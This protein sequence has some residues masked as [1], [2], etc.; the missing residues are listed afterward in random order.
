MPPE[1]TLVLTWSAV[2]GYVAAVFFGVALREREER[3]RLAYATFNLTL[4]LLAAARALELAAADSETRRLGTLAVTV[5]LALCVPTF[6]AFA[7][8]IL[9]HGLRGV[10]G[11]ASLW[12]GATLLGL[13]AGWLDPGTLGQSPFDTATSIAITLGWT[14]A[15]GAH[16]ALLRAWARSAPGSERRDYAL[17]SLTALAITPLAL[18]DLAIRAGLTSGEPGLEHGVLLYAPV[19]GWMLLARMARNQR[20]LELRSQELEARYAA[21]RRQQA[22]LVDREQL[23]AVGELSAVI[24][25]EVRNPLAV[26]KNALSGLRKEGL[27]AADRETL[28]GIL[29]EEVDRLRRLMQDLLTYARPG[30]AQPTYVALRPL[31]ETAFA[32]AQAGYGSKEVELRLELAAVPA[33]HGDAERL[34]RALVNVL[35]NALR[36]QEGRGELFVSASGHAGTTHAELRIRD[37]GPGMDEETRDRAAAPFFTTRPRGTGLGLAIVERVARTHGGSLRLESAPGEGT[38]VTLVLPT[39]PAAVGRRPS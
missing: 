37:D 27:R 21:L 9:G 39:E 5:G 11:A 34:L 38:T 4:A 16:L 1:A 26:L 35:E 2:H 23:A 22:E 10:L 29:A 14:L 15:A 12:C 19:M 20:T 13:A 6:V 8:E 7:R 31:V 18:R 33:L 30:E 36:A 24:A 32:R 17:L 3:E 28:Q 25:H